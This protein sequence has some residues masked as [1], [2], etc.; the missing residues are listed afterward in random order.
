MFSLGTITDKRHS[1]SPQS[2]HKTDS[3]SN[4]FANKIKLNFIL[5][6]IKLKKKSDTNR[7]KS[8]FEVKSCS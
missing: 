8:G 6:S 5:N 1:R 7:E 2:S 4:N 3:K